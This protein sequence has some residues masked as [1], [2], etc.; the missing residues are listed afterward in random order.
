MQRERKRGKEVRQMTEEQKKLAAE[1]VETVNKLE[2]NI[3]EAA[4]TYIR[5]MADAVH[6]MQQEKE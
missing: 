1:I 2:P 5:G 3:R 4:I 6:M